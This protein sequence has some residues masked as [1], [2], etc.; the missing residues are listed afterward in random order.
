MKRLV[1]D[2]RESGTST[3]RYI[4]KL[5]EYLARLE[6]NLEII[7]L[8]KPHRLEY[9][10]TLAPGFKVVEAD[11]KEFTFDEQLGFARQLRSLKADLVHFGMI[12][13]P[14]LYRG[15]AVTTMHDLT[16]ARFRNINKNPVIFT[17]KQFVY[18]QVIR[19]AAHTSL[20]LIT[21]SQYVKDDVVDYTGVDPA[22]IT[23]TYEAADPIP[24][25]EEPINGFAGKDY[26]MFHG[27]PLP[28]KN[29]E[30][31]IEAFAGLHARRPDLCLMI[32]GKQD[33]SHASY[34]SLAQKLGIANRVLLTNWITD[35][36]LK[37]AMRHAKAYIY[38]SLSE[39]FGL[40]PL[41]AM[42]NGAPV[43]ASNAT[44]IPEVCGDAARYFDPL[45]TR[46]MS[47][48]IEEV[49]TDK[50]LRTELIRRGH[51]QVKKYSWRRMAEQ[52]LAVYEEVL[53]EN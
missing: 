24:E 46:A 1:L 36:Q 37:W 50:Q 27:R 40:P 3:G 2:A 14:I 23:V 19:K 12:H 26:I 31:L 42:L 29:L 51:E 28:H 10:R 48:A 8:A 18:R 34:L 43:V 32:A 33:K 16:T 6:P 47:D 52:T 35:G 9:L 13:Q 25:T 39:G 15:A 4:D 30:R 41:E 53:S 44:C 45:D 17:I 11:H 7:L 49:L 38:P 21:P 5:V 20:A 22:K